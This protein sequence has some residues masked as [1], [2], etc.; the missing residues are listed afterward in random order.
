MIE[1]EDTKHVWELCPECEEEVMLDA[2]LKVQTCP[3]CGKRIVP[4]AMCL[5]CGSI[6]N[7]DNRYC[8]NCCLCHQAYV[9][10]R[11]MGR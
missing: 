1:P 2:E 7:A 4:C 5:A 3:N 9:E 10:N 6:E 8:E 11:E